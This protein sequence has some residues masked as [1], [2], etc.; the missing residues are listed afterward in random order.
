MEW[1]I[2]EGIK[3]HGDDGIG[4]MQNQRV[5]RVIREVAAQSNRVQAIGSIGVEHDGGLMERTGAND[6][7]LP[8]RI[9]CKAHISQSAVGTN[10]L[11]GCRRPEE[12][13]P[14]KK[15]FQSRKIPRGVFINRN[16]HA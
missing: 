11:G 1:V 7:G 3:G 10:M 8:A 5:G 13:E 15:F 14:L 9:L 6:C 4:G 2:G 16:S 12:G